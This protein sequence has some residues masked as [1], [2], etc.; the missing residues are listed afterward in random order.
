LMIID[1]RTP[2]I[3]RLRKP[4][5]VFLPGIKINPALRAYRALATSLCSG[6]VL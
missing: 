3:G 1:L 4:C 6:P 2:W 5:H